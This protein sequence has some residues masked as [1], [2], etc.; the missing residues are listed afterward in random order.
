MKNATHYYESN[1]TNFITKLFQNTY[2][3]FYKNKIEA[4]EREQFKQ[5]VL[6]IYLQKT[7]KKFLSVEEKEFIQTLQGTKYYKMLL[8]K[9]CIFGPFQDDLISF[10]HKKNMLQ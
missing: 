8:L 1:N 2:N 5:K 9:L 6:N 4:I 7:N 10:A 3:F